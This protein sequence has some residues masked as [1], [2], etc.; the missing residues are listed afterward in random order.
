MTFN[1]LAGCFFSGR[2]P[3]KKYS[4]GG[5]SENLPGKLRPD[6]AAKGLYAITSDVGRE[7]DEVFFARLMGD[8]AG[9][10]TA[11]NAE[12]LR[13]LCDELGRRRHDKEDPRG[14]PG[15]A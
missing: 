14:D 13:A 9:V 10:V 5:G 11:D 1:L 6:L 3:L 12:Q 4:C 7:V 2:F 15:E 8:E